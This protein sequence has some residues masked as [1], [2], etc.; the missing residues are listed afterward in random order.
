MTANIIDGKAIA[1][2][3][4]QEIAEEVARLKTEHNL[5]PGLAAVLV[6]S[7]TASQTYV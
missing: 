1:G 5:V 2:A 3:I 6:G 7:N 4:Q